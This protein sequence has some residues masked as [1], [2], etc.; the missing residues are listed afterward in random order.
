MT[1]KQEN[2][3]VET[4]QKMAHV[5]IKTQ[6]PQSGYYK[7]VQAEGPVKMAK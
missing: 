3:S 5:V 1:H 6:Q 7:N 2:W 4:E